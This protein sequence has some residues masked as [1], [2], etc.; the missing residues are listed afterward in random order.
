MGHKL[1]CRLGQRW[2]TGPTHEGI[3]KVKKKQL[4][5]NN[6]QWRQT[7]S[8]E[9]KTRPPMPIVY[10]LDAPERGPIAMS[11]MKTRLVFVVLYT[12]E[13]SLEDFQ[14]YDLLAG[15]EPDQRA[16]YSK[17]TPVFINLFLF[18]NA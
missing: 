1:S 14:R 15:A 17:R 6:G 12:I 9:A 7:V 2:L 10:N 18:E 11:I 5:Q 8:T 13:S 3:H 16:A 4:S